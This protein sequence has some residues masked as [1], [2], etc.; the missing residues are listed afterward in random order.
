[1]CGIL[2]YID[3]KGLDRDN[4]IQMR[5][6]MVHRGPDDA[7]IWFSSD[8][9]IGLAHRRL[10]V[11]DLSEAG[12]QPMSDDKGR[13]WITYNGE[14]YN[15]QEIR[16]E[17]EERGYSFRTHTDTEVIINAYNE[18]GTDC[19]SRFNG[20]FAFGLYDDRKK[21]VFL[22]RDRLGKKPL[23]YYQ[24]RQSGRFVF[25]SELKAIMKDRRFSAELDIHA[26]NSFFTVGYVPSGLCILKGVQKLLP[27]HAMLYE[28]RTGHI[29]AWNYWDVPQYNDNHLTEDELLEELESLLMDAVRM[30]MV[31]DVPLGAFL[32]GGVDSSLVTAMMSKASGRPI[33]TFSIGFNDDAY[34]ELPYAKIVADHFQTDHHEL[35]VEPDMF[36]TLH[37]LVHQYDEPFADS[38]MLPTFFVSK[39]TRDYVTV[40]LSGDGG[41]ELFAGYNRYKASMIDYYSK[42]CVPSF[43]RGGISAIAEHLPVRT[44]GRRQ[45]MKLK[46]S[47]DK[48]FIERYSDLYFNSVGRKSLFVQDVIADLHDDFLQSETLISDYLGKRDEDLISRMTYADM[49]T[50]LPD[51]ILVKVDRASMLVS[52]EVRAPL[53]D[54]RIAEFSFRKVN[55]GLKIKGVTT[56]Y[57]L[58]KLAGRLLPDKLN[59]NRKWGFTAPIDRWFR[60]PLYEDLR[61]IVLG[62]KSN[63]IENKTV[64]R[65]LK[66]HVSGFNHSERLFSILVFCLWKREYLGNGY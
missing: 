37:D 24:D 41:D 63:V 43:L 15:F 64:E 17:L 34:N 30:R 59:I 27:A 6:T 8:K 14:I 5:D 16:L 48:A 28:I 10:S 7:G 4:I 62:D 2:G 60:G 55:S 54:H 33:K 42:M 31:S 23:Y 1:M 46:L 11:I 52:L 3:N 66:E 45:L 36:S 25:A 65:L 58:K 19:L 21:V 49:K 32:S 9:K 29:N 12:R 20:M 44:K 50:Y 57:L 53:L 22:A 56:K 35:M 47:P 61:E 13:I 51:D 18:W 40:A 38:S 39:M 26:L